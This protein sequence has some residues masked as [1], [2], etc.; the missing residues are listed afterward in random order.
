MLDDCEVVARDDA[1]DG[2]NHNLVGEALGQWLEEL[3]EECRR[4]CEDDDVGI[5]HNGVYI[6]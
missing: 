6:V 5:A 3:L 2:R 1:L 4:H